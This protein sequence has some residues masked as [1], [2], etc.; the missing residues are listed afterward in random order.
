MQLVCVR[1]KSCCGITRE[2]VSSIGITMPISS[3]RYSA[4][5]DY[6]RRRKDE[7]F[8][9]AELPAR[10]WRC[11]D[12]QCTE[13]R[14]TAS[15]SGRDWFARDS[16]CRILFLLLG[17]RCRIRDAALFRENRARSRGV[18]HAAG[19]LNVIFITSC[20]A[21]DNRPSLF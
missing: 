4:M 7:T 12:F 5:F 10:G 20:P 17:I 6:Q 11:Y 9:E 2:V 15:A 16:V 19:S 1:V 18:T 13:I 14:G 21:N 8:E 3:R